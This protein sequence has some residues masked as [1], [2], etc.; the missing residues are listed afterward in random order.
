L[1][2][3]YV[4]SDPEIAAISL[5]DRH[6]VKMILESA[7]MLSTAHRVLDKNVSELLYK[8]T[9]VNHPSN[10]W[11]RES[12]A[13]YQWLYQHFHFLGMEYNYRY[14]K[15]HKSIERLENTL[16]FSPYNLPYN[17]PTIIPCAMP[18][19]FKIS[20]DPVLNYRSYYKFGK[21]HIHSWTKRDPPKWIN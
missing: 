2:I 1:N 9:H 5:V 11:I 3:F 6:V 21:K 16:K 8:A 10:K 18:D 7:Q 17:D 20:N 4:D 15:I 12:R 14:G 13:N 19:E